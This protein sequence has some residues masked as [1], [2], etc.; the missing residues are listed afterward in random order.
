M[1][2]PLTQ[3][4]RPKSNDRSD[5]DDPDAEADRQNVAIRRQRRRD[6]RSEIEPADDL[7]LYEQRRRSERRWREEQLDTAS[8]LSRLQGNQDTTGIEKQFP[9]SQPMQRESK[10]SV[11]RSLS[12]S[13]IRPVRSFD[14]PDDERRAVQHT[15]RRSSL[16]GHDDDSVG[17]VPLDYG[18]PQWV[19]ANLAGDGTVEPRPSGLTPREE[20]IHDEG[21]SWEQGIDV[22]E[23][24][25][26]EWIEGGFGGRARV[27]RRGPDGGERE[28]SQE[29]DRRQCKMRLCGTSRLVLC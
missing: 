16:N 7:P 3:P 6:G 22:R 11:S 4:F 13:T 28:R 29:R 15:H 12:R 19:R 23:K 1:L 8:E 25:R 5:L 14:N 17:D 9:T 27:R 2:T 20:F 18:T 26:F 10:P 24:D 21:A